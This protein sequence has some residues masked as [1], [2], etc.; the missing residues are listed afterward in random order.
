VWRQVDDLIVMIMVAVEP[1]M[2]EGLKQH[3]PA[4]AAGAPNKQCFQVRSARRRA[5]LLPAAEA[6]PHT[7]PRRATSVPVPR[8]P[9]LRV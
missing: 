4:V 3:M 8:P 9:D 5:K 2:M 7:L 6:V 1:T